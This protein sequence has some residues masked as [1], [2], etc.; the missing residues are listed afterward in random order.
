[1]VSAIFKTS[2]AVSD[3]R[4]YIVIKSEAQNPK[5]V[6]ISKIQNVMQLRVIISNRKRGCKGI[7]GSRF[8]GKK[9]NDGSDG[10][11]RRLLVECI[12]NGFE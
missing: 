8:Q 3:K 9:G 12:L 5:Q 4:W 7:L 1:M 6:R 2:L 10:G 11:I